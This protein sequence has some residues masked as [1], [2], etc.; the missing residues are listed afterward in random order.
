MQALYGYAAENKGSYPYGFYYNRSDPTTWEEAPDTLRA[1]V[2]LCAHVLYPVHDV[3]GQQAE[4]G[5]HVVD[6]DGRQVGRAAAQHRDGT[7]VAGR[8]REVV[9]VD[10]L[11]R[12]RHEQSAR[13]R[14]TGVDER[15]P[16]DARGAVGH[17]A[18]DLGDLGEAHLDHRAPPSPEISSAA[19]TRS[20]NG[21]TTPSTS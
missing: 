2:V 11:P 16:R 4:R 9:A 6:H 5:G 15:S 7:G 18:H 21:C 1:D 19:T 12:Q 13:L 17:A 14:R 10:P 8:R 3:A 20:S